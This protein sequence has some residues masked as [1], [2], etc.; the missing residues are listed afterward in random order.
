MIS[1]RQFRCATADLSDPTTDKSAVALD[2]KVGSLMDPWEIPG[3]AHLCEHMLFMGTAK[4]PS[5]NEYYKFLATHAGDS[6]AATSTDYTNF[7]FD[8]KPEELPGALD[9]FVQFFLSPL[10]TESATEREVCA[11]DSEHKNNLNNDSRRMTQ[12]DRS[13]SKPGHDFRKFGTGNKKTLLE[14]TRKQGID[15]RD[16]LLQFHKKWFRT[17]LQ[18]GH[19]HMSLMQLKKK[20]V[21]RQVW[22]DHPYGP[23][24]LGKKV[25][26]VPIKDSK[27]LSIRFPFPDLD[28]EY[29]SQPRR[30]ISHLIGDEAPGSLLSELKRR[31]WVSELES[32]YHTPASGFAFFTVSM[33]LSNDGLDHVDEIIELMFNYIGMLRA[34]RPKEWIYEELAELKAITFRFKDKESPMSLAIDVASKLQC[35]PFE[36]ILS[37]NYL[38]TKYDP[39]RIK[40]LLDKLT[41]SNM[42]I[43]VLAQKFKG[44]E[45]SIIEPIYGT[46]F[47]E[48]DIDKETMQKYENALKTS[49]PAFHLPKKNEYIATNFDLKP[50]EITKSEHPRLIVD[51]S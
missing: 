19:A 28:S 16:A 36:D 13:R 32:G 22:H 10:F 1:E 49:N 5:E 30:Y 27:W 33:D 35:I 39:D 24:Q 47:M 15:L 11:V 7:Y 44:Q 48:K 31:G 6:N 50:R 21:T 3:L 38:L 2:V 42:Y 9:R 41:P 29:K 40:E 26:A 12:V 25:E 45:G 37:S 20:G 17:H 23:E 51:D 46:E 34:K 8:V 14:D 43:R 18:F 4:Y